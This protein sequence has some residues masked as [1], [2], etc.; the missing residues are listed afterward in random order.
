MLHYADYQQL[1][2]ILSL[3]LSLTLLLISGEFSIINSTFALS[4]D[5]SPNE[6]DNKCISYNKLEKIITVGCVGVSRISGNIHLTD[7]HNKRQDRNILDKQQDG[8]WLLNAGIVVEKGAT[9]MLDPQD[10]TWLKII[11]DGINAYPITILGSLKVDSVKVTSWNPQTNN[12]AVS[13]GNR[14]FNDEAGKYNVVPGF[15]RPYI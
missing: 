6:E 9:L 12:Y 1:L 2:T 8:V 5:N 3:F 11:A 13:K 4:N 7:I 15:P 10:T 14:D